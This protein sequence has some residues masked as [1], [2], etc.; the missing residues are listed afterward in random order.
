MLSDAFFQTLIQGAAELGMS[1]DVLLAEWYAESNLD[2]TNAK[3]GHYGLNAMMG[4]ILQQKGIDP[5]AY[6]TWPA[7]AQLPAIFSDVHDRMVQFYG[8]QPFPDVGVYAAANICPARLTSATSDDTV[9]ARAGDP[10][11]DGQ[12]NI[13]QDR[14]GYI[15][16]GDLRAWIA[17]RTRE[18]PYQL[19]L[20]RLLS[21]PIPQAPSRPK[22]SLGP[23][24]AAASIGILFALGSRR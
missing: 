20:A 21:M 13:D 16:L 5:S 22:S 3:G 17:K 11:Y 18:A 10:C 6:V 15:T 7:E 1:P 2:P 9:F 12:A 8:G 24:A 4:T 14:K 23:I 19:A